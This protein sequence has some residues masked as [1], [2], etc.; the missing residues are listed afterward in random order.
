MGKQYNDQDRQKIAKLEYDDL[1]VGD[2][3][4]INDT[5]II[6]EVASIQDGTDSGSGEQV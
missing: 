1:Q 6:G 2:P 4:I 5:E 3:A